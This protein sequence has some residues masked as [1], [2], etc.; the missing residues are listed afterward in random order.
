MHP[1]QDGG[2]LAIKA[3]EWALFAGGAL[4]TVLV[5]VLAGWLFAKASREHREQLEREKREDEER[6]GPRDEE[7]PS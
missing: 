1:V 6:D 3:S 7:R 4:A 5:L 2:V